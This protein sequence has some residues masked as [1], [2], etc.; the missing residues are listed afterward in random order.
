MVLEPASQMIAGDGGKRGDALFA[1]LSFDSKI[2]HLKINVVGGEA[3][4]LRDT[5]ARGVKQIENRPISS[6]Q[7]FGMSFV[8]IG[9]ACVGCC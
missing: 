6:A 5:K 3:S 2:T 9:E 8:Q 7:S 1:A 4:E